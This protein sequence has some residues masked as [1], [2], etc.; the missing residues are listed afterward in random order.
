MP[1]KE[2]QALRGFT[3]IELL[4]VM[5]IIAI[6]LS[7]AAPRYFS[8][9]DKAKDTT[10]KQNLSVMRD[11]IDKFHADTNKYPAALEELVAKGY[12]RRIPVDPITEVNGA[13]EIVPPVGSDGDVGVFDIHSKAPGTGHDG[14]LYSEY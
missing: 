6:L 12:L 2:N 8:H 1:P 3:L 4:V 14:V 11:A 13:W 9:V 7:I 5:A 10:L